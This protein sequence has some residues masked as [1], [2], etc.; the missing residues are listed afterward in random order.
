M[1]K[2][3][4]LFFIFI[5]MIKIKSKD[6]FKINK[7][8]LIKEKKLLSNT[9]FFSTAQTQEETEKEEE[10]YSILEEFD[11]I[12][13]LSN[14]LINSNETHPFLGTIFLLIS[15]FLLVFGNIFKKCAKVFIYFLSTL[16]FLLIIVII[17]SFFQMFF[18]YS[19]ALSIILI[20]FLLFEI[21]SIGYYIYLNRNILKYINFI[22]AGIEIDKFLIAFMDIN[23]Y[24]IILMIIIPFILIIIAKKIGLEK[25]NTVYNS[26]YSVTISSAING[27]IYL[28][29][30]FLAFGVYPL[31]MTKA[32]FLYTL[33]FASTINSTFLQLNINEYIIKKKKI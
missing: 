11:L 1:N 12:T 21:A 9:K 30:T 4:F 15:I 29:F 23:I 31:T 33:L 22:M 19:I 32:V 3:K 18:S 14:Y 5:I 13:Q 16:F 25:F 2:S 6:I 10:E 28:M 20:I 27:S 17:F 8:N 26:T 7:E 24:I